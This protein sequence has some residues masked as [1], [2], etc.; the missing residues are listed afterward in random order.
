MLALKPLSKLK[1]LGFFFF[2]LRVKIVGFKKGRWFYT[3]YWE[4]VNTWGEGNFEVEGPRVGGCG[5]WNF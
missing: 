2:F 1:V 5:G 4:K 3:R